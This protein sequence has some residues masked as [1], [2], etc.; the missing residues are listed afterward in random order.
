[1]SLCPV[2]SRFQFLFNLL[3]IS[4]WVNRIIGEMCGAYKDSMLEGK[5]QLVVTAHDNSHGSDKQWV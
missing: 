4:K 1:M 2:L 5:V 3:S